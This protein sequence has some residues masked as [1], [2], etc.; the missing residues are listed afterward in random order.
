MKMTNALVNN[1]VSKTSKHTFIVEVIRVVI[2][3]YFDTCQAKALYAISVYLSSKF[4]GVRLPPPL[5][6]LTRPSRAFETPYVY[7]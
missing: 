7:I 4:Y 1:F 3:V 6:H 5:L 2:A